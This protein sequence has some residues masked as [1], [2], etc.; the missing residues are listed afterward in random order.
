MLEGRSSRSGVPG[1]AALLMRAE[2]AVVLWL[3]PSNTILDQTADA[4]RDP[5]HPYRRAL[6]LASGAVE[7]VTIE[8]ALHLCYHQASRIIV[9]ARVNDE[10]TKRAY[11]RSDD[12]YRVFQKMLERG[13]PPD[14]WERLLAHAKR[15]TNRLRAIVGRARRG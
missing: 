10:D 2:C 3:V 8:E 12:A 15:E 11:E 7:V 1:R 4:L 13:R 6:E 5:R 14:D 9:Y